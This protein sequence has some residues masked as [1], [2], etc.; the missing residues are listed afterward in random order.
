MRPLCS[1]ADREIN[2]GCINICTTYCITHSPLPRGRVE[3]AKSLGADSWLNMLF[4]S[5]MGKVVEELKLL[6]NSEFHPVSHH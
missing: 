2:C 1:Q 5:K 4:N 6:Y 3:E